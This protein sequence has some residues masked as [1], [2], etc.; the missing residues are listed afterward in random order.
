LPG[1]LQQRIADKYREANLIPQA[2]VTVTVAAPPSTQASAS[3]TQPSTMPTTQT[4]DATTQPLPRLPGIT[5]VVLIEKSATA[6]PAK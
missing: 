6:L 5:V 4:A 3:A 1:E 2:T